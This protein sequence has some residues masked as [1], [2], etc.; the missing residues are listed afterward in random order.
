MPLCEPLE[1]GLFCFYIVALAWVPF[2]YGSNDWMAWAINAV[3]FPGLTAIYELSLLVRRKSHPVGMTSL[4]VSPV[5]FLAVVV[6]I[7]LQV[8]TL[9]NGLFANP[10]WNLAESTLGRPLTR[11]IS[12]DR[13]LTVLALMRLLTAASA[14]WLALQLCREAGRANRLMQSIVAIAG[15]YALYGLVALKLGEMPWLRDLAIFDG[16]VS[17]TFINPNSFAT[18]AAIGLVAAAALILRFYGEGIRSAAGNTRLQIAF[19]IERTDGKGAALLALG[20]VI[21]SALMLTGSRGGIVSALFG[22]FVLAMFARMRRGHA[23]IPFVLLVFGGAL[24]LIALLAFQQGIDVKLERGGIYD[25]N[26]LSVYELTLRSIL[27]KPFLG[28]GYG[29][30]ADVFP[31]YRDR[32]I[33][34]WGTWSEAHDTYLEIFQGLGFI[35]GTMLIACVAL[36]AWRCFRG[37]LRR[38]DITVPAIAAGAIGVV[39]AHAIVD[40]SLQ[41][42]AITLTV[43]AVLGAG[44]AQA[45]SIRFALED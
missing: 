28:Y 8:V 27:N 26:R 43:M 10:I 29:T 21:A 7:A 12:V 6:W 42:Q 9:P 41:I 22:L 31:L 45:E 13:D 39:A 4:G 35:F 14:F 30:F 5:F 24:V 15:S 40:F 23:K 19:L 20:F 17:S 25:A 38:R 36:L 37:A 32:T 1:Q 11:S 16:R 33:N 3:L 34:V 18:Y 2:W 44:V